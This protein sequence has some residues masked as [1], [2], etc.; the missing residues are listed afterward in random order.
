MKATIFLLLVPVFLKAQ[1]NLSR[2]TYARQMFSTSDSTFRWIEERFP[3]RTTAKPILFTIRSNRAFNIMQ[4][5]VYFRNYPGTNK[6]LNT[7]SLLTINN[8]LIAQMSK[9]KFTLP[10]LQITGTRLPQPV[11]R[12]FNAGFI[13]SSTRDAFVSYSVTV[14]AQ[15]SLTAG[16]TGSVFLE[17]SPNGSF[18]T[19][20][21][22]FIN[23]NTGALT[24]GLA[25]TNTQS[26]QLSA[27]V[28]AGYQARLR[29]SG[30][31]TIAYISGFESIL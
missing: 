10:F 31:A 2:N 4:D 17:I 20:V 27:I 18:W 1:V 15:I 25:L 5:S 7:D 23:G 19:T 30:T 6:G 26:G 8:G 29:T 12:A 14:T 28:P 24:L 9:D 3:S 21:G 16:Q 13:P 22:Q 11:T